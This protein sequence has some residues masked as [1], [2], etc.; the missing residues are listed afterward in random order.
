MFFIISGLASAQ[1]TW[2]TKPGM[3][4]TVR[5]GVGAFVINGK[6]YFVGGWNLSLYFRDLWCFNKANNTWTQLANFPG[7]PRNFMCAFAI[8][9]KGYAGLG[10]NGSTYFN[11]WWEYDTLTNVWTQKANFGGAARS[12]AVSFAVNGKGYIATGISS[13]SI[14]HQDVWEYNASL[15]TWTQKNTF[16]GTARRSATSFV[17]GNTA[18]VGTGQG[19]M[20]HGAT[21]YKYNS[22][23][24]SWTAIANYPVGKSGCASFS[25]GDKG[26]TFIGWD[27]GSYLS[28]GYEYD[29]T[30]NTWTAKANYGGGIRAYTVG[31]SIQNIGFIGM[32]R[33]STGTQNDLWAYLPSSLPVQLISF[34][35]NA[36]NKK[37]ITCNWQ[38]ATELNNNYFE[39]QRSLDNEDWNAVGQVKG[40]GNSN[41]VKTYQFIDDHSIVNLSTKN[42][43]YRLKQVDF[44]GKFEYSK[45]VS[46]NTEKLPTNNFYNIYPNPGNEQLTIDCFDNK[47]AKNIRIFDQL[48]NLIYEIN[49]SE[50]ITIIETNQL[51]KGIYFINVRSNDNNYYS[52]IVIE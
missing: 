52:K 22:I 16:G 15:N 33:S 26:Y 10:Y 25:I 46:V 7:A 37:Q 31:V 2:I 14:Y 36:M 49:T 9:G 24:D 35:A 6:A 44:D 11:D 40:S 32:G 39:V 20:G 23:I 5:Q 4:D 34:E 1:N 19:S 29:T 38:T 8:G 43:Y 50:T 17:I 45:T 41:S 30:A 3:P 42:I 13:S 18:Y 27:G 21:F 48:G 47:E 28:S 51:S 12:G